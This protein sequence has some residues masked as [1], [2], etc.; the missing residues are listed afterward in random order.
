[1]QLEEKYFVKIVCTSLIVVLKRFVPA[2]LVIAK[3]V[4]GYSKTVGKFF[5][6]RIQ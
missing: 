4:A 1:M 2:A 6:K 3:L 5:V